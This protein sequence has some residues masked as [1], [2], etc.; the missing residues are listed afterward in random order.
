MENLLLLH[1]ALGS[2]AT[3]SDIQQALLGKYNV[4]TLDFSGHG[5]LAI[6]Q[7]PYSMDLFSKDIL[8]LLDDRGIQQ[9]HIFGY[10]M[11]GYAALYFALQYP[12]R[13]NSIFTLATKFAW[14][15]EAAAKESKMLNP[16]KVEEKVPQ[17]AHTLS[18]RHAPQ[19]WK[20]VMHKTA[21]MMQHLGATPALTSDN[22]PQLQIPVLF[23]IGDRDNMVTIEE[24]IWAYKL[25][26]NASLLVLP[27][28]RH[29][30]ETVSVTRITSEIEQFT[31][32]KSLHAATI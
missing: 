12:E 26:P 29:P 32:N 9:T 6:P 2:A 28:T 16:E 30:L 20:Q 15:L 7:Q 18:K 11:G 14:S 22:M 23:G 5:G 10:S 31:G 8:K 4:Y 19:D 1:G 17:F 24:T 13:V 27:A 25:L 3:L 21:E